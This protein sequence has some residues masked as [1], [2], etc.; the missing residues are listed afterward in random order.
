MDGLG[1]NLSVWG[2]LME[3]CFAV[4]ITFDDRIELGLRKALLTKTDEYSAKFL[5][6]MGWDKL[7]GT[8]A[9]TAGICKTKEQINSTVA[10]AAGG[11]PV[12]G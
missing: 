10:A 9:V 6:G 8:I 2:D 12:L 11:A 7:S 1:W 4:L 3:Y 5:L